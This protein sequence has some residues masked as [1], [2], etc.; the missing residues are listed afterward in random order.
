MLLEEEN[1]R[2]LLRDL[3][4]EYEEAAAGMEQLRG[5]TVSSVLRLRLDAGTRRHTPSAHTTAV[6]ALGSKGC[7]APK[8][9]DCG[10]EHYAWGSKHN[11][12][13]TYHSYICLWSRRLQCTRAPR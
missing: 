13:S 12:I 10:S 4:P 11:A 1:M 5:C 7:S 3:E 6:S 8:T 9:F 2:A